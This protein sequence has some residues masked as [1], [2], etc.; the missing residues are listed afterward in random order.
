[1]SQH[2]VYLS[3]TKDVRLRIELRYHSD[4]ANLTDTVSILAAPTGCW[5][6]AAVVYTSA[7]GKQVLIVVYLVFGNK[8]GGPAYLEMTYLDYVAL[9]ALC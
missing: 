3:F 8:Q 4:T 7:Q 9:T 5:T 2:A 6:L 1:M